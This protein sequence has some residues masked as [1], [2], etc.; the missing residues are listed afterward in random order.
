MENN[1]RAIIAEVVTA[2]N[3]TSVLVS[4]VHIFVMKAQ[5]TPGS[6]PSPRLFS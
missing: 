2:E 6:V 4:F 1:E 5:M 3:I